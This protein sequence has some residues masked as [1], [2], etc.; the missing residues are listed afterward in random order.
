LQLPLELNEKTSELKYKEHVVPGAY[1]RNY[2]FD[3]FWDGKVPEDIAFMIGRV[4]RIA[5]I[6]YE[7]RDKVDAVH[8][9]MLISI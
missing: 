4:V 6:T 9:W 1:I 8:K 3:M 7:D 5:Y 2:A